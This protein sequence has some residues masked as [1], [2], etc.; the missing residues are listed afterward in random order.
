MPQPSPR[1]QVWCFANGIL[2]VFRGDS[3][4][5]DPGLTG[6][7]S[8]WRWLRIWWAMRTAAASAPS[9]PVAAVPFR[10]H[11]QSPNFDAHGRFIPAPRCGVPLACG[12]FCQEPADEGCCYCSLHAGWPIASKDGA[13]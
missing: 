4:F 7:F 6:R 3:E 10:R 9:L 1:F 8:L 2:S 5:S 12:G 11:V 13:A